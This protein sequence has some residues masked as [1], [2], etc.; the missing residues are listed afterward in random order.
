[1]EDVVV[2]DLGCDV[3]LKLFRAA[4]YVSG[5]SSSLSSD[6]FAWARFAC[7]DA[8][9]S[10]RYVTNRWAGTRRYRSRPLTTSERR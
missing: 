2:D 3:A 9:S 8:T 5:V 7:H 10:M 1:V 6:I 4:A